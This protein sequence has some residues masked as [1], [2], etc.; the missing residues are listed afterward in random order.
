MPTRNVNL[1]DHWDRFIE[2]GIASGRYSNASE[3]VR[4]ALRLL[5][6]RKLEY[7]SRLARLKSEIQKGIDAMERGD[8]TVFETDEDL[9]AF[10]DQLGR[11][12]EDKF[13]KRKKSA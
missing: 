10:I 9:D 5:E 4:D 12:A 1:T 7:E 8:Y 13:A 6:E 11:E 3:V 2:E